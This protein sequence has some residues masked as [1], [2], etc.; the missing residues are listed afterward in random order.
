[1]SKLL[2]KLFVNSPEEMRYLTTGDYYKSKEGDIVVTADFKND[3]QNFLVLIHELVEFYLTQK[4]GVSDDEVMK[5]DEWFEKGKAAGK[6]GKYPSPGWHPRSPY[7]KEH[8]FALKI[9]KLIAKE[10]GVDLEKYWEADDRVYAEIKKKLE[11][12]KK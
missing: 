5:F 11:D 4:R 8:L 10:L 6:F 9:E 3:D 12:K 1:M 7:K 2:Y